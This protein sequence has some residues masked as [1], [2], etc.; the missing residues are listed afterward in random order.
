MLRELEQSLRDFTWE[1]KRG[2]VYRSWVKRN[3]SHLFRAFRV[4]IRIHDDLD[5]NGSFVLKKDEDDVE[6]HYLENRRK[7]DLIVPLEWWKFKKHTRSQKKSER[8]RKITYYEIYVRT[9]E[10]QQRI[11]TP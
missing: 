1:P 4:V 10:V 9:P 2:I 11:S 6:L 8:L 5:R 7:A 3:T